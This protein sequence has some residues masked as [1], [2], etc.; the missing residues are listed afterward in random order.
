MS[1]SKQFLSLIIEPRIAR[2]P[3]LRKYLKEILPE[4]YR[5]RLSLKHKITPKST[6]I[7]SLESNFITEI[8]NRFWIIPN[9]FRGMQTIC[10]AI[11]RNIPEKEISSLY[12]L[13]QV[14]NVGI[15]YC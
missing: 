6:S 5:D 11:L 3:A 4:T 9:S 2:P 15:S 7:C 10:N 14:E 13:A 1:C 12:V 8:A